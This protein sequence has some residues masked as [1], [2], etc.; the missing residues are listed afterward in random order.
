[1]SKCLAF[2]ICCSVMAAD[3]TRDGWPRTDFRCSS[4]VTLNFA[5]ATPLLLSYARSHVVS[6]LTAASSVSCR[7]SSPPSNLVNGQ[8]LTICDIVWVSPHSHSSLSV[9]PHFLWHALQWPWPVR[10]RFSSDHWHDINVSGSL[11]SGLRD[12]KRQ[13]PVTDVTHFDV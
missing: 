9:K 12:I 4:V 11:H 5:A 2:F 7:R 10:K 1:M 8:E 3:K 6:Q 13:R